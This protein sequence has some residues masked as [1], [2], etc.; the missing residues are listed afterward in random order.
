MLR[1]GDAT[2]G[3]LG[4]W[5]AERLELDAGWVASRPD[6]V[7]GTLTDQA[8]PDNWCR[9]QTRGQIAELP[10]T[11]SADTL[12]VLASALTVKTEWVTNLTP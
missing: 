3:A 11:V 12:V 4:V 2:A 5:A 1:S 10:L 9:R 7:V 6:G 8:A